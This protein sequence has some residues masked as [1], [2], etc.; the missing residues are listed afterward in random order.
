MLYFDNATFA[1]RHTNTKPNHTIF[2]YSFLPFFP[3]I[4][5]LVAFTCSC[6]SFSFL[7]FRTFSLLYLLLLCVPIQQK[8]SS[9]TL[10]HIQLFYKRL[11]R[12]RRKDDDECG[13]WLMSTAAGNHR[14][15]ALSYIFKYYISSRMG[16]T[17][18]K[19]KKRKIV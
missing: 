9:V 12:K 7:I 17:S 4:C 15:L 6:Y 11:Y 5:S 13:S 2:I 8:H 10:R 18:K 19:K 1:N 3:W 16:F 14:T